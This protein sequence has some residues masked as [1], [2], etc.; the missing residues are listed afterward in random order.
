MVF[1]AVEST[2]SVRERV[3]VSFTCV[4]ACRWAIWVR[5]LGDVDISKY[6]DFEE[7]ATEYKGL[8]RS[9]S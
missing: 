6:S 5:K 3:S 8:L 7:S 9:Q 1:W 4:F 2:A